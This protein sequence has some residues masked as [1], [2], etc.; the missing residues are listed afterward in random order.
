MANREVG[1]IMNSKI[2]CRILIIVVILSDCFDNKLNWMCILYVAGLIIAYIFSHTISVTSA[3]S[4]KD[5]NVC[6]FLQQSI[7]KYKLFV[8]SCMILN[9]VAIFIYKDAEMAMNWCVGSIYF[10]IMV[11]LFQMKGM[12]QTNNV[13]RNVAFGRLVYF[14][15]FPAL[16]YVVLLRLQSPM[17]KSFYLFVSKVQ[18]HNLYLYADFL[19]E[20]TLFW[21]VNFVVIGGF[22]LYLLNIRK[23]I[24]MQY[25]VKQ[26]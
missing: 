5:F 24:T 17:I 9:I 1:E 14:L 15:M 6:R 18:F 10:M 7:R 22:V 4:E 11:I 23:E 26:N 21:I 12:W 20:D 8:G 13:S 2:L 16:Y 25:F 3:E 19:Y